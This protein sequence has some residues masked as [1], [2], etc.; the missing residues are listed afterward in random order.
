MASGAGGW[1]TSPTLPC[2]GSSSFPAGSV[3]GA[4]DVDEPVY[5][6]PD[7]PFALDFGCDFAFTRDVLSRLDPAAAAG[8]LGRLGE[9]LAVHVSGDGVWFGFGAWIV[10]AHCLLFLDVEGDW[11][12]H[13]TW[14][15]TVTPT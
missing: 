4:A 12:G 15:R 8:G 14:A 3:W 7:V 10:T 11:S 2:R 9:M 6:G 1:V 13:D 5:Y